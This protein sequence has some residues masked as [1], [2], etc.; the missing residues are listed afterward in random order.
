M[1]VQ[2]SI[3]KKVL[4]KSVYKKVLQKKCDKKKYCK[5][6]KKLHAADSKPATSNPSASKSSALPIVPN[7]NHNVYIALK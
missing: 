3:A 4:Q 6:K 1:C 7:I 5:K 2:K